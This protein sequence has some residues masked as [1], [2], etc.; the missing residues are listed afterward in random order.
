MSGVLRREIEKTR[1]IERRIVQ[2]DARICR[3]A[4]GVVCKAL[5]PFKTAEELAARVGCAVRTA[6]YE[7]SGER[8]PSAQ[9]LLAVMTEIT[10]RK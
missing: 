3:P 5:W 1:E 2:G 4:F 8:E 7:I 6:A 9:S 10:P